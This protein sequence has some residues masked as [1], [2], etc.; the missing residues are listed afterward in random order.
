MA[1]IKWQY[2]RTKGLPWTA[3]CLAPVSSPLGLNVLHPSGW[4][5]ASQNALKSPFELFLSSPLRPRIILGFPPLSL[6]TTAVLFP[7]P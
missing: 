5:F 1:V 3:D 4:F 7:A 2:Q 6:A